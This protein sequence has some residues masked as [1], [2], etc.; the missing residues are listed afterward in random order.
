M[1]HSISIKMRSWANWLTMGVCL[2]GAAAG[3]AC[4][5]NLQALAGA[6]GGQSTCGTFST[7]PPIGPL[8]G[9]IFSIGTTGNGISDCGLQ[10][11]IPDN[12][13][14][15]GPVTSTNSVSATVGGGPYTGTSSASANYGTLNVAAHGV[16]GGI[17][18]TFGFSQSGGFGIFNDQL[19]FLSPTQTSGSA[20]SV[21]YTFTIGGALTT[22]VPNPPYTAQNLGSL[23]LKQD[24]FFQGNIF[25]ANT[26]TGSTG[27]IL[28]NTSYPGF[29]MAAGSV[30]GSG[31]F[32]SVRVPFKWGTAANLTVGLAAVS[33]PATGSTLDAYL[34]ADLTGI[35]LYDASGNPVS[36][37]SINA[38]SGST[39][40]AAGI[41]S[42]VPLPTSVW[43]FGSGLAGLF[44]FT[45]R[46]KNPA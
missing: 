30:K 42:T 13:A 17:T 7:P 40:T 14:A 24:S 16:M 12:T 22:P 11:S 23:A 41:V 19:T 5:S 26:F 36:S 31:Q 10:G 34:N 25:T 3:P 27:T 21:V 32:S 8:F 45:R 28:G 1:N 6:V 38:A 18:N 2:M 43:L 29:T 20:G 44:G 37:F 15:S 9:A 4:A 39:Y 35:A 46:K 33:F